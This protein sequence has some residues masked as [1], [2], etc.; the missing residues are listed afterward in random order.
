VRNFLETTFNPVWVVGEMTSLTVASSGH[1]YFSLKDQTAIIR[2]VVWK[3]TAT[4]LRFAFK[5]GQEVLARGKMTV[6]APRGDYQLVLDHLEAKGV[7]AHDLALRQL[8][9]KLLKLG[10]FAPE[11]KRSIP[12]YPSRVALVTSPT[13]AAIRDMLEILTRRWP[14]M[15]VWVCPVRV[16]GETAAEQIVAALRALNT[17]AGVDMAIVARGGGSKDDLAAFNDEGVAHAIFQS[18]IPI[19]SAVGHEIDVTI[20]DLVADL[21]AATPSEAAEKCTPNRLELLDYL[22]DRAHRLR[23]LLRDQHDEAKK[24]LDLLARRRV[25]TDPL[26]RV[27]HEERRV[28]ENSERL[29][30]AMQVRVDAAQALCDGQSARLESLS[31]LNVL[32]RGYSLTR[33]GDSVVRTL[34]DAPVGTRVTI[35][36]CDGTLDA[37]VH[38]A[39]P[40]PIAPPQDA[41]P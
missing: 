35:R 36:V 4:K 34:A 9:E 41:S 32:A 18:R 31:P 33:R 5:N 37:Q 29:R 2:A 15:E 25:L 21:R 10:Y 13:G 30:R 6:Y 7:G 20:A 39:T 24:H 27:R 40:L 11:R 12:R 23:A 22:D 26:D 38:A 17:Q 16:Q 1:V 19:I 3:T 8:K 28:D 14:L